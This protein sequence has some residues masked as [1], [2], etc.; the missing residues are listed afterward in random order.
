MRRKGGAG[1]GR[2]LKA[3]IERLEEGPYRWLNEL[4]LIATLLLTA[5]LAFS[6]GVLLWLMSVEIYGVAN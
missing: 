3:L 6:V 2:R 4:F 5:L 1:V